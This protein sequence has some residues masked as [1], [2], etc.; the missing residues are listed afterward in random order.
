MAP[1]LPYEYGGRVA[2]ALRN[3]LCLWSH[4]ANGLYV[5]VGMQPGT[6]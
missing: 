6:A 5:P 2:G 1:K 4:Y 3:T